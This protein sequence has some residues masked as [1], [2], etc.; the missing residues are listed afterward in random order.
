MLHSLSTTF[1]GCFQVHALLLYRRSSL[2]FSNYSGTCLQLAHHKR[3]N[4]EELNLSTSLVFRYFKSTDN[5][6]ESPYIFIFRFL[7]SHLSPTCGACST[8][9]SSLV[10]PQRGVSPHQLGRRPPAL[11]LTQYLHL[12][13]S[14]L[15]ST[16][17]LSTN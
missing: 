9:Q 6:P 3:C 2:L 5:S 4:T 1:S 8:S 14:T 11:G 16:T 10:L 15:S 13:R 12:Y 7:P 17:H